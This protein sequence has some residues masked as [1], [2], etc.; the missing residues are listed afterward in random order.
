M[1]TWNKLELG[2]IWE[3]TPKNQSQ[4]WGLQS[5]FT[6]FKAVLLSLSKFM[7]FKGLCF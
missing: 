5:L 2:F 4:I 7:F 3:A 1:G 6:G